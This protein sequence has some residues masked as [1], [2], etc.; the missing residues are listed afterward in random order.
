MAE[1][2]L[3]AAQ[4][5][6]YL[7]LTRAR[8]NQLA[9]QGK[10]SRTEI[11]GYFLYRKGDLDAYKAAPKNKGGRPKPEATEQQAPSSA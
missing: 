3:S 4:A 9:E 2:L 6:A 11:G 5:A 8:I 7:G 10:L 1:D